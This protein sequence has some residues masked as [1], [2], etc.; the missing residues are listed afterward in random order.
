[1]NSS[2]C[3]HSDLIAKASLI[4]AV[5]NSSTILGHR[6]SMVQHLLDMRAQRVFDD[7]VH[8]SE[9]GKGLVGAGRG[10]VFT[11][12]NADT[13]RRVVWTLTLV[14]KCE[15]QMWVQMNIESLTSV[16]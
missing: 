4:W 2:S 12:G 1:M 14:R 6:E 8:V 9:G 5:M 15:S 11:A 13:L 3:P 16:H 7:P 10:M